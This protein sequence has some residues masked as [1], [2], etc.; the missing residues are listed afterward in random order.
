LVFRE[1]NTRIYCYA[2]RIEKTVQ[3]AKNGKFD[4]FTTSL[5]YSK[6]Q[7]HILIKAIM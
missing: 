4:A 6:F 2:K 1:D 5:L 7:K 3:I